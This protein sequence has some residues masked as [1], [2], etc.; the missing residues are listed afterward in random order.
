M[1]LKKLNMMMISG[2]F[3]LLSSQADARIFR[4]S[5]VH[6]KDFPTNM[7][8]AYMSEQLS[9]ATNGKDS[10]KVFADGSLGSEK[11]TVEQVKIGALD[12][13]RVSSAVFNGIVPESLIPSLPF[14]FRDI[15]HLRETMYGPQGEKILAAFEK[16]GFIGLA[17]YE[18]GARSMYAKKPIRSLADTKGLKLR[19]VPERSTRSMRPANTSCVSGASP[20]PSA[21]ANASTSSVTFLRSSTP[22]STASSPRR[23]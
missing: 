18:S 6:A 7:A 12:M 1:K 19:A 20:A 8:L 23:S 10:I 22:P 2:I 17:M 4:C 21:C 16:A 13:V 11:D 3:A 14:L 5:E 15:N 9:T